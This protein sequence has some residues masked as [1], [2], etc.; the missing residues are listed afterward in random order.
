MCRVRSDH[1]GYYDG[2][3]KVLLCFGGDVGH[4]VAKELGREVTGFYFV[5][6]EL[7]EQCNSD[8]I[9]LTDCGVWVRSEIFYWVL[10]AFD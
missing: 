2:F 3:C 6:V 10:G 5:E 4:P 1:G 7:F 8:F 9:N